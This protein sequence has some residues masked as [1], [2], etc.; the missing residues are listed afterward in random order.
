M[1]SELANNNNIEVCQSLV[2]YYLDARLFDLDIGYIGS[3]KE[4]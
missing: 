2:V 3:H 4:Q 1:E